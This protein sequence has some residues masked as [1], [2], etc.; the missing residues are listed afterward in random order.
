ML[1]NYKKSIK[2]QTRYRFC[3]YNR[4]HLKST[5][6]SY[7]SKCQQ[8]KAPFWSCHRCFQPG[9][10]R[11]I[12]SAGPT[13][14]CFFQKIKINVFLFIQLNF[15][16]SRKLRWLN[17]AVNDVFRM[18]KVYAFQYLVRPIDHQVFEWESLFLFVDVDHHGQIAVLL[19]I[20]LKFIFIQH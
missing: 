13:K 12:L 1:V 16:K 20:K 14:I 19:F 3:L 18:Q 10:N 9:L 2:K 17:I 6:D 15:E 7:S 8:L 5:Q 11:L 4:L